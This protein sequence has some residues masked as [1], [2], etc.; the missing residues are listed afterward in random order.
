MMTRFVEVRTLW[1]FHG[2]EMIHLHK[3]KSIFTLRK[4]IAKLGAIALMAVNTLAQAPRYDLVL[5]GGHVIDPANHLDAVMD[6]AVSK[7]KIAAVEKDIPASQAGKLVNAS[8]LYITPGLIDIHFHIGHGGA[9]LNWFMPEARAHIGPLG[10]PADLAL[11]SGV[12]TLV[13]AGTAG[14]ETFLQEKEEVIDHA[15]VRVLAFLNIVANGMNGGLEQ[16]GDQMDPKLCAETIK[17]YPDIIVGVKTAHFWTEEPWD[18]GHIPWAA[19]DRAIECGNMT[20]VPVMFDFWPRPERTYA[21]LILKKMRPG[22]I[23]THVFA[24]QFPIILPDGKLNPIMAEAHARGV[25]F[26]VGHGAGSFWF[27]N[28]VPA[29]RQG[30]VPDSISTDLHTGNYTVLSMNNVMSKFLAM[31]VPL[32]DIIR[33]STVNPAK[34]IHRPELGT[35]SVGKDADI[36]VLE[37]LHGQFGY[38][39]CGVARMDGNVKLVARMT[40]RAGKILYDP[41]GLSMIE[42]EKARPQY[43]T[44]PGLGNS[45]PARADD[46]P[47]E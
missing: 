12:T 18:A 42:W 24:Q 41:S 4:L 13:D 3:I 34:E 27:R 1:T 20:N 19:V 45:K 35:L 38:I 30:F 26:D 17:K 46:F 36:A 11:Q 8:G 23:H 33:R 2:D 39:D 29:V 5:K 9:P 22:D 16:S 21:D 40:V 25:I 31:G 32:E 7:D 37:E 43:F 28:A 44:T 15:K 47:R 6:V 10:I 14:A